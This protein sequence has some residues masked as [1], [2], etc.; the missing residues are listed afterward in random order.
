MGD[1]GYAVPTSIK[2]FQFH[3]ELAYGRSVVDEDIKDSVL[4]SKESVST[5]SHE[6]RTS[7][8]FLAR[9]VGD[10]GCGGITISSSS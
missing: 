7:G 1:G 6:S 9:F 5:W 2:L 4:V 3:A 8:D 10:E